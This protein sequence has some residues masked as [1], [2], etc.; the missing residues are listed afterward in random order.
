MEQS[1]C[2]TLWYRRMTRVL[3]LGA[4]GM[5]GSMVAR[6]LA[7]TPLL[8]V[9]ATTR[10][11]GNNTLEFEVG[12]SSISELL[13]SAR[14][15]WVVNALGILDRRIDVDDPACVAS[16]IDVNARFP[17]RLAAAAD[18]GQR[19]INVATDGVFSGRN[20]PYDER[21][22]H[23]ADGLYSRSKSLG[24]VRSP[25]VV[26]LRCS[27]IGPEALP[28]TSLLGW[29]VSQP[30]GATIT[31]YT[32]HR[33]NG[34]TTLHFAKVCSAVILGGDHDLPPTL[35]VVPGDSV[36]KAELLSLGLEAF[37]RTD[38]T[39]VAEP[40]SVPVDRTLCTVHPEING[41]LWAAAG[42]PRPPRI[43]DMVN[44]LAMLDP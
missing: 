30:A 34:L 28:A 2:S 36:S 3:V 41:H 43:T 24:E 9:V 14:C 33:W 21:A 8:E 42:Y 31:G 35:H 44:E 23:D 1:P 10:R 7:G 22:M 6:V 5:L 18:R 15:D 17:H 12:R 26:N 32:N 20:A 11:G 38:V 4:N 16:V 19:V 37:G 25:H 40:A 29:A 13:D 39:V 27:I